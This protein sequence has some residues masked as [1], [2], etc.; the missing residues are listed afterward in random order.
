LHTLLPIHAAK[1]GRG[2]VLIKSESLL[3]R[4]SLAVGGKR[5]HCG[6]NMNPAKASAIPSQRK[7]A[8]Q[9]LC[10]L[11]TTSPAQPGNVTPMIW[12]IDPKPLTNPLAVEAPF[13]VPKSIDAAPATSESGI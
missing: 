4:A 13:L 8:F 5:F 9:I 6:S 12:P 7:I 10:P 2:Q 3:G 1:A 11:P